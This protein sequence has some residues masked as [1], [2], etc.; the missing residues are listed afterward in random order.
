[1]YIFTNTLIYDIHLLPH[2]EE[3]DDHGCTEV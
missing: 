3:G 2:D 1:M